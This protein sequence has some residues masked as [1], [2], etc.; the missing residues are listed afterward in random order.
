MGGLDLLLV[1]VLV[2]FVL[3]QIH[4][5]RSG[6]VNSTGAGVET[7][8]SD[9]GAAPEVVRTRRIT[10]AD[11]R[12]FEVGADTAFLRRFGLPQLG[13]QDACAIA[14]PVSSMNALPPAIRKCLPELFRHGNVRGTD[15]TAFITGTRSVGEQESLYFALY[16]PGRLGQLDLVAFVDRAR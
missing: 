4:F 10:I 3:R 15:V 11:A 16:E 8:E 7:S 5:E 13:L 1:A 2:A 9:A 14:G 12:H 6:R